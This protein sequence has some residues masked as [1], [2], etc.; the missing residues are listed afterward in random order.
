M[1]TVF[2]YIKPYRALFIFC[3]IIKALGS[4]CELVIPEILAIIIDE[5][6]PRGDMNYVYLLGG[7]MLLL[8]VATLVFNIVAN[9]YAAKASG[10]VGRDLRKSLFEKTLYLD[11]ER[12]DKIGLSS[13]TSRLTS[14][15]YNVCS[16]MG[17]LLRMGVRAPLMTIGGVIITLFIEWRLALILIG[18]LPIVCAIVYIITKKS[19]PLYAEEQKILDT[20]VTKVDETARGIKVIKALSK[21]EY[22]KSKFAERSTALSNKEIEAGS[23]TAATKPLTDLALNIGF[24]AVVVLGAFMAKHFGFAATGTLLA[25]MTY[26]TMILMN[27]IMMTRIFVQMSRCIASSER[28][29]EVLLAKSEFSD[30]DGENFAFEDDKDF[31]VFDNVSFSYN[32]KTE[33]LKNISFSLGRG[34]T[35]GII[36]GTGSGKSTVVN[37][38][39][40]LYH[41]DGGEI[42]IGGKPLSD[43]PKEKLRSMFGVAFQNDFMPRGTINENVSFFRDMEEEEIKKALRIARAEDFVSALDEG[44][45]HLITSGGT[46]VSGGQRQ[47]LFVARALAGNPEV[48][49]LDDASSALDYKTDMELRRG[50][51]NNITA[52]TIIIAQRISS[53][54][55]ADKILVLKDGEQTGFGTHEELLESNL[56][57][58]EIAEVQMK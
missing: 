39:L 4:I 10:R 19:I 22:E 29:A 49:I 52:T 5:A 35:L 45:E 51:K 6:V 55:N 37:L 11:T 31:I 14:D 15:T 47:R 23:L 26:F 44:G 18:I 1:K 30:V 12:T 57:Y 33:N 43:I 25:F 34:E 32:K 41:V 42:R 9:R 17:R 2:G 27:M 8:A 36:G 20:V 13:L 16:F 7:I 38:L 53:I 28:I 21:T 50:I 56:E 24:C 46:N 48:I 54:K 40:N 3:L 58:K